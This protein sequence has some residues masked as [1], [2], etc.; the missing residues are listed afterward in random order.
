MTVAKAIAVHRSS[1]IACLSS[2]PVTDQVL[3]WRR[4]Q[5]AILATL[6]H[7]LDDA[8]RTL[9]SFIMCIGL[10]VNPYF[11]TVAT[12]QFVEENMS[13]PDPQVISFD[14]SA[15]NEICSQ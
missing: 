5:Q 8:G 13:T 1:I 11:K 14:P 4:F 7:P 15:D 2:L 9:E 10:S 12:H 3:F 6:L